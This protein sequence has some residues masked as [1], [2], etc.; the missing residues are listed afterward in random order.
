MRTDDGGVAPNFVQQVRELADVVRDV[1][2]TDSGVL[3]RDPAGA[4]TKV[5][6]PDTSKAK[7][8]LKW[9]AEIDL[10]DRLARTTED[11]RG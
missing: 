3:F 4:D 7:R 6:R 11:F 2:D 5:R 1:I 9:E 8:L 10:E